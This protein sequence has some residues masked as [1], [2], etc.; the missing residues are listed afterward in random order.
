MLTGGG[1]NN[2]LTHASSSSL[3]HQARNLHATQCTY[4]GQKFSKT[5]FACQQPFFLGLFSLKWEIEFYQIT[6]L[7]KEV[8]KI[9]L[10]RQR[11]LLDRL[12]KWRSDGFF[13]KLFLWCIMRNY[14][15]WEFPENCLIDNSFEHKIVF[16]H[17]VHCFIQKYDSSWT[18]LTK[19]C[20][21]ERYKM[22]YLVFCFSDKSNKL[23]DNLPFWSTFDQSQKP[24][25]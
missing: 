2:R 3:D 17:S 12:K 14:L 15:L 9:D 22:S 8:W 16:Y 25:W 6:T 4:E 11:N 5:T 24:S 23:N 21:M 13:L 10:M 1:R 7:D 20:H 19:W 18:V